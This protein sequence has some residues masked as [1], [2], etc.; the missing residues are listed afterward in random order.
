MESLSGPEPRVQ[1]WPHGNAYIHF[2]VAQEQGSNND[3]MSWENV[4]YLLKQY[5][6]LRPCLDGS[7]GTLLI[8]FL[9]L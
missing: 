4:S 5:F 1:P 9:R 3:F 7:P 6:F 8:R 2:I